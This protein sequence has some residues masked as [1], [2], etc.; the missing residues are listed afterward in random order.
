VSEL[1]TDEI[2]AGLRASRRRFRE[3]KAEVRRKAE[4]LAAAE[5]RVAEASLRAEIYYCDRNQE[6]VVT[7]NAEGREFIDALGSLRKL[8]GEG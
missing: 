2:A 1:T 6:W 3:D 5:K 8:K 4:E 7:Y